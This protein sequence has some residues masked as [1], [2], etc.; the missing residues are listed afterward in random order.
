MKIS[1]CRWLWRAMAPSLV[2]AAGLA[3]CGGGSS[4]TAII[5]VPVA[6][7]GSTPPPAAPQVNEGTVRKWGYLT[8]PDGNKMR[9]TVLLPRATGTFPVLIE[10][11]GYGSGVVADEAPNWVPEG[12]AVMGLN[13]PGTGCSSGDDQVFDATVGAAG[14]FAVEWAAQQPWSSGKVGMVGYSYP[15]YNQLW[16]AAQRPKGLVAI[17]PGKNVTDPYRDVGY[18]GGI[19]NIGFPAAWWGRF[20]DIWRTSA[21]DA[22]RLDGDTECARNVR[23]NIEKIKRPDLDLVNWLDNDPHYGARYAKKS[24]ILVT[25]NIDIPTLGTQSWQDEQ[26][27]PRMG[28]YE[29]TIAPEKMWLISSNGLHGTSDFSAYMRDVQR[30]F[31]AHFLKGENN[32]FEREPHVHLLQEMQETVGEKDSLTLVHTAAATFDRLPVKTRPMRLWLQPGGQLTDKA[33]ADDRTPSSSYAYPI[34]SPA[35][36]DQDKSSWAAVSAPE[37]QQVFTTAP[38]PQDLSFYGEGSADLYLSSTAT[39]TDLQV[40]LSEVRPDGMEMFV[41]RGWLRASKRQLD[42]AKS[43]VLRPTGDFTAATVK[44]LEPDTP[45]LM[46][47]ELQKFAHVF[48]A[49]SSLRVTIDTPS[50][51]GYW[52]FGIRQTPATN[53][54]WHDTARASSIVLGHVAYPHAPGLPTCGIVQQQPCRKNEIAVPSGV[55]PKPPV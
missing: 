16:V 33:P 29:D 54:I 5:P 27:G 20:P 6:V 36:N 52:V 17:A 50:Q 47:L 10:Y 18:P 22:A 39:D 15:G 4:G 26:V 35:V 38:L 55:G 9:Y 19:Q 24:A 31:Y 13:V 49:G 51:T 28:Y 48:R 42:D 25:G 40:S 43:T 2:F 32:G 8:L 45:V 44:M 53:R 1:D 23:D 12:Y 11:D 41:Q 21:E 3:G 34:E 7:G 30:R 14:A 37:G 46:R